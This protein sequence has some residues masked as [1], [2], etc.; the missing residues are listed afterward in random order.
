MMGVTLGLGLPLIKALTLNSTAHHRLLFTG[1]RRGGGT[2]IPRCASTRRAQYINRSRLL[3]TDLQPR[4][5]R[6]V[7]QTS[8]SDANEP[9]RCP[10]LSPPIRLCLLVISHLILSSRHPFVL[11]PCTHS[12][13]FLITYFFSPFSSLVPIHPSCPPLRLM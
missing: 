13:P 9:L 12:S 2:L 5:R 10:R 8:S 4:R 3:I 1:E 6:R 11:P 7:L